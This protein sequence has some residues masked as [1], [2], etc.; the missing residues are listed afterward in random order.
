MYRKA[1]KN[2]K[3]DPSVRTIVAIACGLDLDIEPLKKC[4]LL[5]DVPLENPTKTE[6]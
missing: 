3:T 2:I 4:Y 6:H 5:Q 1:E